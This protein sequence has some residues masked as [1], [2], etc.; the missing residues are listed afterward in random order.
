MAYY[1]HISAALP[2]PV[3]FCHPRSPWQRTTNEL[4]NGLLHQ[5][6]PKRT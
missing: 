4:T 1:Q 2:M 3:Y 5:Y 6:F